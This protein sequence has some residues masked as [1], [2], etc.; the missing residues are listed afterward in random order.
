MEGR[1]IT[2]YN[3][4]KPSYSYSTSTNEFDEELMKR[5]IIE[6]EQAMMAKGASLA[7][8]Q[9]LAQLR[10]QIDNDYKQSQDENNKNNKSSRKKFDNDDENDED[11]FLEKYRSM[12]IKELRKNR[13][14]PTY[15]QVI[16]ISRPDWGREVNGDSQRSW[17]VVVLTSSDTRRTGAIE[18]ATQ[19]LSSKF[20]LV[21]FVSIPSQQAIENWPD[22]NLPSIFIYHRGTCQHQL[23]QMGTHL[24]VDQ[25]EWKLSQIIDDLDTDLEE[26][27]ES[28][29]P[30]SSSNISTGYKG[31]SDFGGQ[32]SQLQTRG[33]DNTD[34]EEDYEDVD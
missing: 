30:P 34:D 11:D 26:E 19:L 21:K 10:S 25:V 33:G 18:H 8:A 12:R 7:E 3:V 5:N 23:I 14:K 29:Q 27:P 28:L 15:G 2:N 9:R 13:S 31:T 24:S 32:M 22:V 16:P 1:G 20:P 17:V 6:F 4:D